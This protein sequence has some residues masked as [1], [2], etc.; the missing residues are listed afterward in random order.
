VPPL[1]TQEILDF[2]NGII[3]YTLPGDRAGR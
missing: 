2:L 1:V 3:L